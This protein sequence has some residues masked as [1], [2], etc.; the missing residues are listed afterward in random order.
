M[1]QDDNRASIYL[2]FS[3]KIKGLR[4]YKVIKRKIHRV[5]KRIEL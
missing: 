3:G 1:I 4:V 2:I 5:V